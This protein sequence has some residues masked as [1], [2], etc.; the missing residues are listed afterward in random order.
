M[1]PED[2]IIEV[3]E[4]DRIL[5]VSLERL[6]QTAEASSTGG[7]RE[8]RR[9]RIKQLHQRRE[10]LVSKVSRWE[11]QAQSGHPYVMD[12]GQALVAELKEVALVASKT[13]A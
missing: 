9:E 11:L 1:V 6:E 5:A 4:Q 8:F 10:E 3:R 7:I 13:F 12:E 2:L